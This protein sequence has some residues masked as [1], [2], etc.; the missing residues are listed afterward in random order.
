MANNANNVT[1]GKPRIGGGVYVAPLGTSLP[2]DAVTPLSSAFKSLGYCSDDGLTN[3]ETS[4]TE[5]H[6]AWG[7]DAVLTE[8][9][10]HSDTFEFTLIE[11]LN[12]EVLKFVYGSDAVSGTLSTGIHIKA[13]RYEKPAVVLVFEMILRGGVLKRIVV[14]SAK[15]ISREDV[16]YVDDDVVG[17]GVTVFAEPDANGDTHH[18]YMQAPTQP[19]PETQQE[20]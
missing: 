12:L 3:P 18:D 1:T 7:G 6:H 2:T 16:E 14:P 19:Q 4:E 15:I 8:E 13:G 11:I 17:F 20:G 9:T 5:T 10:E